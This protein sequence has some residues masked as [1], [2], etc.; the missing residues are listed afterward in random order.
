MHFPEKNLHLCVLFCRWDYASWYWKLYRNIFL[1]ALRHWWN[2]TNSAHDIISYLKWLSKMTKKGRNAECNNYQ[3]I[4]SSPEEWSRFLW[5]KSSDLSLYQT[6]HLQLGQKQLNLNF[7]MFCFEISS[8]FVLNGL[9]WKVV[10]RFVDI[11]GIVGH[12]CSS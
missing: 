1:L 12:H 9:R 10:V 2:I 5:K 8:F 6:I 4:L 11:G 3:P 7:D